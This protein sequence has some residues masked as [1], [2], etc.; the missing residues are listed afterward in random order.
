MERVETEPYVS[1]PEYRAENEARTVAMKN[2]RDA[3]IAA[4]E[5]KRD[6]D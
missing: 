2:A 6:A 5:A 3:E 4:V 1:A